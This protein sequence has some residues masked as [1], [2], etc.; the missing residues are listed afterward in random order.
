MRARALACLLLV[1][2]C[3]APPPVQDRTWFWLG[4]LQTLD[5]VQSPN[6]E[7]YTLRLEDGRAAI[8][9]DC[10]RGSG[11]VTLDGGRIAFG[12]LAMTRAFCP[13]PSRGDEYARLL[14][15]AERLSVEG[16]V[17]RLELKG[18]AAMF[19]ATDPKARV[20]LYRCRDQK[21]LSAVFAGETAQVWFA[22]AHYPL[23]RERSA[24]GAR[25]G[26]GSVVFHTQGVLGTL[27]KGETVLAQHCQIPS[28]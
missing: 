7:A 2:S 25:Y 26:D 20:A 1:S 9:A 13:P 28:R 6:P 11:A 15:S 10:N 5:S 22:G 16:M 24:S 17:L 4:S 27:R 23:Q 12:P 14:Q 8:R 3:A 19:F 21:T 18:G